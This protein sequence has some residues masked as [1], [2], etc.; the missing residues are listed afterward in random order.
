MS[1]IW[2]FNLIAVSV[3]H[4]SLCFISFRRLFDPPE[5]WHS[6]GWFITYHFQAISFRFSYKNIFSLFQLFLFYIA[7]VRWVSFFLSAKLNFL[8]NNFALQCI[9]FCSCNFFGVHSSSVC[10]VARFVSFQHIRQK[11][12]QERKKNRTI[13]YSVFEIERKM[14]PWILLCF[15]EICNRNTHTHIHLSAGVLEWLVRRGFF[16]RVLLFSPSI[17]RLYPHHISLSLSLSQLL[18]LPSSIIF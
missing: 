4:H 1:F 3:V 13:M 8:I 16:Y 10:S 5:N 15:Y 7:S 17:C 9:F 18:H 11:V 6:S 2:L 14:V 12:I